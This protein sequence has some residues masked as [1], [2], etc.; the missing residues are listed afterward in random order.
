MEAVTCMRG[1]GM[2]FEDLSLTLDAGGAISVIGPNGAGKSSL[3]RMAAGLL[4]PV[5]GS[6]VRNGRVALADDAL[7]LDAERPLAGALRFWA[8]LDRRADDDVADALAAVGLSSLSHVPVRWLS[9]GQRK[10]AAL[11]R[12]IASG[13]P[14]WLLDEP[15]NGLDQD[16]V[17]MLLQQIARHRASGGAVL[18]ATHLP[19]EMAGARMIQL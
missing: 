16:G 9:T 8:R 17:T 7:A 10:R 11:A 14:L 19:L 13:A 18:V 1:R 4:T 3:L 15:A 5:D 6:V 2:L 12:V